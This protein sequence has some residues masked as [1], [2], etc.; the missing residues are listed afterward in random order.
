[1][2]DLRCP[3]CGLLAHLVATDAPAAIHCPRCRALARE[4]QLA[5]LE[6]PLQR[7]NN[8]LGQRLKSAA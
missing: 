7:P 6:D 1:M 5:P 2:P 4:V 3:D 8:S